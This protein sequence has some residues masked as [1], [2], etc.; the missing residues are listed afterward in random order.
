MSGLAK[1]LAGG[2]FCG[3]S[4]DTDSN[5]VRLF[6]ELA[7]EFR[8]GCSHGQLIALRKEGLQPHLGMQGMLTE[9]SQ[10]AAPVPSCRHSAQADQGCTTSP[11][12]GSPVTF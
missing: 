7:R 11:V 2:E 1:P 8:R 6:E 12:W 10:L 4:R 5:A 9:P 3:D